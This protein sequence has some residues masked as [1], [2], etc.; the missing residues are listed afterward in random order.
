MKT[1]IL[2]FVNLWWIKSVKIKSMLKLRWN[3]FLSFSKQLNI[4]WPFFLHILCIVL[5]Q[6]TIGY[7]YLKFICLP[8]EHNLIHKQRQGWWNGFLLSS[9]EL[10]CHVALRVYNNSLSSWWL[11]PEISDKVG[12]IPWIILQYISVWIFQVCNML[13][14]PPFKNLNSKPSSKVLKTENQ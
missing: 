14:F 6:T 12:L 13:H 3:V 1:K 4:H 7:S 2:C 5:Q 8:P 11:L 10:V 9:S